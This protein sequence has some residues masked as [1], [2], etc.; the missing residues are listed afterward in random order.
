MGEGRKE[1]EKWKGKGVVKGEKG[2]GNEVRGS[3]RV[4]ERERWNGIKG[5]GKR[6]TDRERGMKGKGKREREI[7]KQKGG[8]VKREQ[9]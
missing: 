2:R 4:T 1:R 9:E 7:G 6:E 5:T 3:E 8:N